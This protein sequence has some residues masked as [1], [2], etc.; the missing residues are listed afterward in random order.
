MTL[1]KHFIRR[2]IVWSALFAALALVYLRAC[3]Y[4][5]PCGNQQASHELSPNG[6]LRSWVFVRDCGA[7]TGFTS[8]VSILER[9]ED[10]PNESGNVVAFDLRRGSAHREVQAVWRGSATLVVVYPTG[11]KLFRAQSKVG[12]VSIQ[13]NLESGQ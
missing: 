2:L 9:D 12:N 4:L 8:E 10:L 3:E 11:S 13:Y 6:Q 7:T 5:D 1:N